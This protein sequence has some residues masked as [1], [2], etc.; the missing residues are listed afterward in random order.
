MWFEEHP[1][2]WADWT[3][4]Y[5]GADHIDALQ[6]RAYTTEKVTDADKA[7]IAADLIEKVRELG[8]E[9][10]WQGSRRKKA[11]KKKAKPR[12][13]VNSSTHKRK[14]DGTVVRRDEV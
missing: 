6:E 11:S 13:K 5:F 3:R 7:E 10:V 14:V 12:A 2:E 8:E 1:H 9:P 4:R